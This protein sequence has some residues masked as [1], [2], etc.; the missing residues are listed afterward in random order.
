MW[1]QRHTSD[2]RPDSSG[3]DVLVRV[4]LALAESTTVDGVLDTL[5]RELT[6]T[7]ARVSEC[8]ISTWDPVADQLVVAAVGYAD[9]WPDEEERGKRYPL[10][11]YPGL[12]DLLERRGGYLQ[13]LASDASL[14]SRVRAQLAEWKWQTWVVVSSG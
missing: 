3:E 5:A 14:P 1:F 6:G 2:S 12:R 13:Y 7:V 9:V 10:D 8:T 4:A 11:D